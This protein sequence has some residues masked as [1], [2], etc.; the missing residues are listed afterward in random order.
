MPPPS[1][2]LP[3]SFQ[4][5]KPI[6]VIAGREIY[7]RLTIDAIRKVGLRVRLLAFEGETLPEII[8]SFPQE[9]VAVIKVGQLGRMLKA[10]RRFEAGY[11][12]MVGQVTPG[13]LFRGLHP[14][15]RA[16]KVLSKISERNAQ[17]IFGAIATEI[18]ALG[19]EMLDARAFLDHDIA[20]P[21]LMTGD[22]K[23]IDKNAIEH[24]IRVAKEVARLDIGQSIV[25]RRGTVIA[26]EAFE[27]TDAM[28][29]RAGEFKTDN[30]ILIKVV[31]PVQDYRFDV[32]VFGSR[33]LDVMREAGIATAC[34]EAGSTII[35]E[36]T[37][38]LKIARKKNIQI[39]GFTA[40][41]TASL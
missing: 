11:A 8:D 12:I 24:G 32:P 5:D 39:F 23:K 37:E 31:K 7:P 41:I 22:S 28:L 1:R 36:K 6:A 2:F 19:V 34:L 29:R 21:G 10:I 40:S 14:D 9:D 16:I 25:V 4:S 26:V 30:L 3:N 35:L 18:E 33:T 15:F 13:R 27:G 17:T 38:V 20:T